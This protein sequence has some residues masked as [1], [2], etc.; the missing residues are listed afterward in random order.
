MA[1]ETRREARER[2]TRELMAAARGQLADVGAAGLS[3]REVAREI[4]MVSSAVYRYVDSRDDL[5]TRLIIESYDSLGA[6]AE[7]AAEA[8]HGADDLARWVHVARSIRTWAVENVH[9]Y[10]LLYGT[11]VP[12]YAAPDGTIAAGARPT[13]ALIGVVQAAADAGR[14]AEP[15]GPAAELTPGLRDELE[16]L[17]SANTD[18]LDVATVIA[19][20][21]A[22][23]QMFGLISFELTSQ[24]RNVVED[25][26]GLFETIVRRLGYQLG[27]RDATMDA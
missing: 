4:G 9:E 27:L 25:H 15:A 3:L 7:R 23:T 18:G 10:L 2:I 16:Q 26:A 6:V 22:W 11:P 14:L 8:A 13:L 5:L 17:A 19:F 24:T 20:L 21:T 12:G 1:T